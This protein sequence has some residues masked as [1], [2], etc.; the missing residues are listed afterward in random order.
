MWFAERRT[1]RTKE[2]T[3]GKDVEQVLAGVDV[4][5]HCHFAH[6]TPFITPQLLLGCDLCP[7]M[8]RFNCFFTMKTFV[9]FVEQ[10]FCAAVHTT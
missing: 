3:A 2:Q 9:V 6:V 7:L 4:A 10:R 1:S 5:M 8:F